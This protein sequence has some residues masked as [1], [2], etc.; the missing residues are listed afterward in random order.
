VLILTSVTCSVES[1]LDRTN[2]TSN[3]YM[4]EVEEG[5]SSSDSSSDF[6]ESSSSSEDDDCVSESDDEMQ[7]DNHTTK[8]NGKGEAQCKPPDQ[9]YR[10]TAYW[11]RKEPVRKN[12]HGGFTSYIHYA[13]VLHKV[14]L[15]WIATNEEVAI[16]LVSWKD[17]RGSRNR[18]SEDFVKEI[19]ALQHLSDWQ[20][21]EGKTMRDSHVLTANVVMTDES[22][23]YSVM[24]YCRG[25]DLFQRVAAC[26]RF[27]E[28]E[29]RFWF[30]QVLKGL[31]TL[32]R[33]RICH[34]DLSPENFIVLDD[35][36]LVI[37][38]GMCLRI[39]YSN[40]TKERHLITPQTVCG[41]RAH[42]SPEIYKKQPF[43]GHAVDI[44]GAST[45]LLFMLTGKRL[46]DPPLFDR[47]FEKVELGL[48]HEATDLLRKMFR[49]DPKDRLTLQQIQNHPFLRS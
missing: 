38:F 14:D 26:E 47:A 44:W 30:R 5:D 23:L 20:T 15:Y 29:A 35:E 19:A 31:E 41:K 36:T 10:M 11:L 32:Q 13:K 25:G 43:D 3:G 16:K 22:N 45:V 12:R 2:G 7:E 49:L 18:L 33:A 4:E 34:R 21:S 40:D 39:P 8:K 27:T 24:Q 9:R 37:D 17:I 46:R 1:Q 28:D 42:M 6:S 48:S